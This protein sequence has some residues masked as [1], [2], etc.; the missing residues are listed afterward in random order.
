MGASTEPRDQRPNGA[1]WVSRRTA[2]YPV[3]PPVTGTP[4]RNVRRADQ[5]EPM[6]FRRIAKSRVATRDLGGLTS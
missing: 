2:P 4:L 1:R 5:C 3:A 6:A